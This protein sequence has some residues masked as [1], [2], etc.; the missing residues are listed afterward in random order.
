MGFPQGHYSGG[1][2]NNQV[3]MNEAAALAVPTDTI[4]NVTWLSGLTKSVEEQNFP[5]YG[6]DTADS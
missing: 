4:Q 1:L 2:Y 6:A 3:L 5:Y